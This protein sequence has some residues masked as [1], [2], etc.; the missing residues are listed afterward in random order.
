MRR[1][2]IAIIGLDG[3]TFKIVMPLAKAGALPNLQR[4][5]SIGGWGTLRSTLHPLSP[6]AWA[7][8]MT[9]MNPGKHGIFDFVILGDSNRFQ[10][11]NGGTLRAE[12]LWMHLSRA[13]QRVAVVNVPMT[14]PPEPVNGFLIAG[15]DAPRWDRAS[16]YPPDL[17]EKLHH[18]FGEYR[19]GVQARGGLLS[20]VERFI[21]RYIGNLLEGVHKRGEVTRYLLERYPLDFL[22]VV[23]TATDRVQHALGHLIAEGVSPNDEIGRV[24]QACDRAIGRLLEQMGD[25]WIVF[26]ISDHGA[27]TYHW[28][29][30]LSTWLVTQGWMQLR[31]ARRCGWR[32]VTELVDPVHRRLARMV[33]RTVDQPPKLSRFLSRLIWEETRAFA[34][35]AFGSIYVNLKGR[36]PKGTVKPGRE[37][38]A[39]CAEIEEELLSVRNPETGA[40]IVRAVH[41]ARQVYHGRYAHLAPDL[42]VDTFEDYFVRSNIDHLEG[43]IVYPAGRYQ[44]RLLPH[45]ARHTQDG[46][47]IAA[48]P[49]IAPGKKPDGARLIDLAPTILYLKGLPVPSSMDGQPLLDWVHADY[50]RKY[51]VEWDASME[52]E[53]GERSG[54]IYN[55]QETA[56]VEA[57]LRDLGYI[58]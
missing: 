14:Y 54:T 1:H 58:G 32:R 11:A 34:L 19:V 17:A 20:S 15:M 27:C 51:P 8:F 9:G 18:L 35:G 28:V 3:A 4:L 31:P 25:E 26:V 39:V 2:K 36:F 47:L 41:R 43:R 53:R 55:Q 13:G 45:T 57:R 6:P 16:T 12:T 46:I 7:S 24:Y 30:E 22:I 33:R 38:E 29:F 42:L 49:P 56:T 21:P 40:P 50:R 37:Y 5:M 52:M 44:G 48:G 10:I 23:F